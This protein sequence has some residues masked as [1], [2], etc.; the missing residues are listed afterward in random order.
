MIL[1]P[2]L[3]HGILGDSWEIKLEISE[4]PG[5]AGSRARLTKIRNGKNGGVAYAGAD[6]RHRWIKAV[7]LRPAKGSPP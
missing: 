4:A 2:S 6:G 1:M 5:R 3:L 7:D